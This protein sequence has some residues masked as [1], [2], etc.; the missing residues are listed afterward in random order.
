[1][2]IGNGYISVVGGNSKKTKVLLPVD[3]HV[4]DNSWTEHQNLHLTMLNE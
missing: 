3:L 1:M 2:V 4:P